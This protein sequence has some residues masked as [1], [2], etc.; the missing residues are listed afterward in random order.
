[1]L[2]TNTENCLRTNDYFFGLEDRSAT[3]KYKV[4]DSVSRSDEMLLGF[5]VKK[6][7]VA[8]RIL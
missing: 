8:A 5:S 1:M 7:P 3:A 6:F 2:I 4:L